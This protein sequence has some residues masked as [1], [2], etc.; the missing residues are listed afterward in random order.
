MTAAGPATATLY[1][2]TYVDN[3]SLASTPGISVGDT[4]I[5]H[6]FIN[7]A[8][9]FNQNVTAGDTSGFTMSAGSY[10]ASHSVVWLVF[11]FDTDAS[12]N[13]VAVQFYGTD[14]FS[15]NVDNFGSTTGDIVFG[16][17]AFND[18]TDN[19]N[20][21]VLNTFNI[22]ANWTFDGAVGVPEPAS[23]AVLGLGLAGVGMARRR[24]NG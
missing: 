22:A 6:L 14:F 9:P 11:Q 21:T 19:G 13:A 8:S 12:G 2:Y 4:L 16:N 10:T 1:Q 17:A 18:T 23:M 15:V 20:T 7:S 24:K 5:T 3:I